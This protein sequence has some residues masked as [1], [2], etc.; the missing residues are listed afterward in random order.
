VHRFNTGQID[1]I[2]EPTGN[3]GRIDVKGADF[4]VKYRLPQF[5][6]GNFSVGLDATYLAQYD[7]T[8]NPGFSDLVYHNAGHVQPFGSGA[9]AA[10]P[11]TGGGVCLFPRWRALATV[12]WNLG[13]WDASWRMRYIGKFRNGSGRAD[14]DSFPAGQC[15]YSQFGK[16]CALHNVILRYGARTYNDVQVGYNI[17]PINTRVDVGIDNVGDIQPP[18]LWAN[19]TLNAN[20][21]PGN[22]DMM[23]RYYFARVTVKF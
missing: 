14:Q 8:P 17:E 4:S 11:E 5:S 7:Q 9:Q 16:D 19:N 23:G 2:V 12:N 21:D 13:S 6:F 20:T 15:Y 18:Y 3:V 10:C 1:N 22:F